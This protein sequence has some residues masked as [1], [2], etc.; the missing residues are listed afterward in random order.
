MRNVSTEKYGRRE[1]Q[2]YIST[3]ER[4]T[5]SVLSHFSFVFTVSLSLR[6][7]MEPAYY[8]SNLWQL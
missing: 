7:V 6:T 3:H 5:T 1:F 2:S 4:V 8:G